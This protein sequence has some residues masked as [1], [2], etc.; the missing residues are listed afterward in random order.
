MLDKLASS[1]C[2]RVRRQVAE[3]SAS[4]LSTLLLLLGDKSIEVRL[5]LTYNRNLPTTYLE[6]LARDEST[7]IRYEMAEN[8]HLPLHILQ[9]L[10]NDSNPYVANRALK[11]I[12][13][14]NHRIRIAA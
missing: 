10:S 5:G 11:T 3:N 7:D 1:A 6:W 13:Q 12:A 14:L 8:N 9:M 4:T 2:E